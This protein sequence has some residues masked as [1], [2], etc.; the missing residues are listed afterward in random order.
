M[1]SP[2]QAHLSQDATAW[3]RPP[4]A[5]AYDDA[6]MASEW[7]GV[8][9]G[10][11]GG[12]VGVSGSVVVQWLGDRQRGNLAREQW[13]EER[14]LRFRD[15]RKAAYERFAATLRTLLDALTGAPRAALDADDAEPLGE[16]QPIDR[17]RLGEHNSPIVAAVE[18]MQPSLD[19]L[20]LVGSAYVRSIAEQLVRET[21]ML[22][23]S[24]GLPSLETDAQVRSYLDWFTAL[25]QMG[26]ELL[27]SAVLDLN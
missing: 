3:R 5:D 16:G 11:V 21:N 6:E 8:V 15:E 7:V 22:A 4:P 17:I 23:D 25:S 13:A 12:V 9:G 20:Q 26:D 14:K 19:E 27:K 2:N 10:L 18:A 1:T 24:T